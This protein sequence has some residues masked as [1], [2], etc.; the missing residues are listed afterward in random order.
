MEIEKVTFVV[1][2]S[3]KLTVPT[4]WQE[5][6]QSSSWVGIHLEVKESAFRGTG[7]ILCPKVRRI[8]ST[9]WEETKSRGVSARRT[10]Q[11]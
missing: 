8:I 2:G 1:K 10:H 7:V 5:Q 11:E 3:T 6:I 9:F 4:D